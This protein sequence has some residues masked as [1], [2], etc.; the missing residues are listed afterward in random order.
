[1]CSK[2]EET[3]LLY[4]SG[5]LG[6]LETR[7]YE[8]HLKMCEECSEELNT[9]KFEKTSFFTPE[10]LGESPSQAVDK[11]L[12]RVCSSAKKQFAKVSV[13]PIFMKK[14]AVSMLLLVIGFATV[15]YIKLNSEQARA[16]QAQLLE[17][18][19]VSG[20]TAEQQNSQTPSVALSEN[21]SMLYDSLSRD[22]NTNFSK[23][24]GNLNTQGVV[25]VD[26]K[27]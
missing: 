5:E 12:I 8:A 26:L 1:M 21:D 4:S 10:I 15:G 25:P 20:S 16:M 6:E 3:G 14:A 9:Y 2:W 11:E 7:E 24:R 19:G 27:D 18:E 17:R 22:S 23:T 13:F